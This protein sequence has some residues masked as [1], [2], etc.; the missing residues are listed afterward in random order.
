MATVEEED[1]LPPPPPPP[2]PP[3]P[4]CTLVV[5]PLAAVGVVKLPCRLEQVLAALPLLGR[6]VTSCTPVEKVAGS[7]HA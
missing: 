3:V 1:L 2:E 6:G 5:Q 4:G 7:L